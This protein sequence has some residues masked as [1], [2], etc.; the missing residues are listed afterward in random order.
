VSPALLGLRVD[1]MNDGLLVA[2]LVKESVRDMFFAE[3]P[4]EATL[5]LDQVSTGCQAA[6]VDEIR[7]L[8]PPSLRTDRM[9]AHA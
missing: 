6:L 1:D 7:S 9:A 8:T 2:W 4:P 5:L 3:D